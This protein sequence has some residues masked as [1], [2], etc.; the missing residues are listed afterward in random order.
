MGARAFF[1]DASRVQV[2][3]PRELDRLAE[4]VDDCVALRGRELPAVQRLLTSR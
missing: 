4:Q 3:T 2:N 1:S